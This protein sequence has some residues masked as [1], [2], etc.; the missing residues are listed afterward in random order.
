MKTEVRQFS[1]IC[2]NWK[3]RQGV[4][5]HELNVEKADGWTLTLATV[6]WL[7]MA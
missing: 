6:E 5:V 2:K 3:G 1:C 4:I 7:A